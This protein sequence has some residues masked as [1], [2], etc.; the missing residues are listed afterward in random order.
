MYIDNSHVTPMMT[1]NG[2]I[3]PMTVTE[4]KFTPQ[5]NWGSDPYAPP[6]WVGDPIVDKFKIGSPIKP[7]WF[8]N[9]EFSKAGTD[10]QIDHLYKLIKTLQED[11][12]FLSRRILELES[13]LEKQ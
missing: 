3:I 1:E 4:P 10:Y 12:S 2:H 8:D 13:K 11:V 7:Q 9:D 6:F 5:N